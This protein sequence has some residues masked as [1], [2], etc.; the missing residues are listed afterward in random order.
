M[1]KAIFVSLLLVIVLSVNEFAS[2]SILSDPVF[3]SATVNL[4]STK[5]VSFC[6]DT[7][8]LQSSIRVT[9]VKLYKY[10]GTT[11]SFVSSLTAPTDEATATRMYDSS[12]DYS[13]SIGA[14]TYRILATFCADGYS[15][16]R[17][18]NIR[19]F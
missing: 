15:I 7:F 4:A 17:Y 6:A 16:S 3:E 5:S 13:G 19:T 9:S 11:W 12:K 1:K 2:A 8:Y 10:N 18:S 14:G